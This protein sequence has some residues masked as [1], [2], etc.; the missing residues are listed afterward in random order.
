MA[1][2]KLKD[3]QAVKV[4]QA[5]IYK[6]NKKEAMSFT[7]TTKSGRAVKVRFLSADDRTDLVKFFVS[8]S[9]QA[10]QWGLPPY[11]DERV[12]R[13][14]SNLENTISLVAV[15]DQSIVGYSS[16]ARAVHPRRRGVCDLAIYLH[17]DFQNDGLGAAMLSYLIDL[18]EK[19]GQRRIT[20][21]VIADNKIAVYLYKKLGF[22]VEGL[23]KGT[24]LGEDGSYHDELIMGLI[25]GKR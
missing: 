18:A 10:V 25:F 16:I 3:Q 7:V 17:Q 21:H 6:S 8:L 4:R 11:D 20:L 14:I 19:D 5:L 15:H 2:S 12:G 13:W 24:Y 22:K 1:I 9:S 23:M